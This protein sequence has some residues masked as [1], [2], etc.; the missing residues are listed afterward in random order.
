[1]DLVPLLAIDG[2]GDYGWQPS[3]QGRRA[4]ETS[5]TK[6]LEFIRDRKD[7]YTNFTALVRLIKSGVI[8]RA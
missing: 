3:S 5:V 7:A 1:M 4:S 2:P 8:F 6:Q